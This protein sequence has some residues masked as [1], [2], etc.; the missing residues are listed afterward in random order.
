MSVKWYGFLYAHESPIRGAIFTNDDDMAKAMGEIRV[1]GQEKRYHHTRVGIGGRMDT[2][3]CAVVLGKL[4][5][6]DWE[7]A[8]RGRI[9]AHYATLFAN[10]GPEI[11]LL[12][13]R[14]DRTS[15]HAQYTVLVR[16]RANAEA[17]LKA[18][19]IPT[20]I[21]YP[22]PLH[23]QPAYAPWA[24]GARFPISERLAQQVIS[25]PMHADLDSDTQQR[26]AQ[27]VKG[28]A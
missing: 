14:L 22:I 26:I 21:H 19:G 4:D 13:V 12:P 11:E 5:R 15:V 17:R 23:Q 16:D 18:A 2:I 1:H 9:G 28:F 20:A 27:S 24:Q 25:L 6:F 3:Q 8:Q 10:L 7:V